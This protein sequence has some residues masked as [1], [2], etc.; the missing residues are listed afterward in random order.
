MTYTINDALANVSDNNLE[1]WLNRWWDLL[2]FALTA[3]QKGLDKSDTLSEMIRQCRMEVVIGNR[4]SQA[5][6]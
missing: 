3:Y 6:F 4:L 5:K 2:E 1:G